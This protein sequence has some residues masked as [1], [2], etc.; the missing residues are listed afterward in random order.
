MKHS[1]ATVQSLETLA[2]ERAARAEALRA[3]LKA[4]ERGA[5]DAARDA[6]EAKVAPTKRR[7]AVLQAETTFAR[8]TLAIAPVVEK[9]AAKRLEVVALFRE[10]QAVAQTH[11][12]RAS[13]LR[14]TERQLAELTGDPRHI[15]QC[16][17]GVCH[18]DGG[19]VG[20]CAECPFMRADAYV[21]PVFARIANDPDQPPFDFASLSK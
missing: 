5:L 2:A 7:L 18:H 16:T 3:E 17:R 14:A 8:Y 21:G 19:Q 11:N 20:A 6:A 12:V 13:D 10:A 9:L 1:E 4:E 15:A